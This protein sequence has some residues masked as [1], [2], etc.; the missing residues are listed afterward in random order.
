M[1][2]MY[3]SRAQT[4]AERG[5]YTF[6]KLPRQ[7]LNSVHNFTKT[8]KKNPSLQDVLEDSIALLYLT[9]YRMLSDVV[10]VGR[11]IVMVN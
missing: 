3:V 4:S 8:S 2:W 11:K 5:L 9:G 6:R 7:R 10:K 1:T